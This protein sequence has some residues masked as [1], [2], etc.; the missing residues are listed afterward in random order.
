MSWER[1]CF[2]CYSLSTEKACLHWSQN[3][4]SFDGLQWLS[5]RFRNSGAMALQGRKQTHCQ[6]RTDPRL[7]LQPASREFGGF[8]PQKLLANQHATLGGHT[9]VLMLRRSTCT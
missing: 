9:T 6:C 1:I 8:L 4:I 2:L 5:G 3:A 7:K